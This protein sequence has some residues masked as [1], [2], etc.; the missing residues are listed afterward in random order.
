VDLPGA[1]GGPTVRLAPGERTAHGEVTLVGHSRA[2]TA[3]LRTFDTTS[4][5]YA[6][7]ADI[8]V[9]DHDERWVV[10]ATFTAEPATVTVAS[11]DGFTADGEVAGWLT[12]RVPD[13]GEHRLQ[14]KE[15]DEGFFASFA[16]AGRESGDRTFGFRFLRV[17]APDADGKVTIDFNRVQ[18]P[19]FAFSAAFLCPLPSQE[20]T[21]DT[22][23]AAGE[24]RV[25]RAG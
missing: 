12:F 15:T 3:A 14:V 9:F 4:A 10:P 24:K 13:G 21:L 7:V 2:G 8:D 22:V 25:V 18:L 16:D 19:A 5:N 20:N 1:W 17:P 23:V 6:D 11:A